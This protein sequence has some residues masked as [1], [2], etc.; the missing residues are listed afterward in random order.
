MATKLFEILFNFKI[1][2]NLT[3]IE[4]NIFEND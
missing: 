3:L 4:T 1:V 2:Q